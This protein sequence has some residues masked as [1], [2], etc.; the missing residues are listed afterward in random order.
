MSRYVLMIRSSIGT[1]RDPGGGDQPIGD[2]PEQAGDYGRNGHL[3]PEIGAH[4]RAGIVTGL[5][6]LLALDAPGQNRKQDRPPDQEIDDEAR[7]PVHACSSSISVPRKSLGCRNSTG[8]PWAPV[9][10]SPSPSTRAPA[11]FNRSRAA[12]MSSTS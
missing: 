8:L 9:F 3:G 5:R 12:R 11:A 1:E 10:G 7:E 2:Q 4:R 6:I